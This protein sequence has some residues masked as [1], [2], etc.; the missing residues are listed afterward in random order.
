M[1]SVN[2]RL[3][4]RDKLAIGLLISFIAAAFSIELYWL[5]HRNELPA[6]AGTQFYARLFRI[7]SAGDRHY[8]DPVTALPVALESINV[9]FTQILNAW[10]IYA[11]V[12]RRAYR[13][14]LQLLVSSYVAYSVILYFAEAHFAG[15][16]A[17][18]DKSAWGFFIFW[19]P[20]LPWL[21]GHMY[22]AADSFVALSRQAAAVAARAS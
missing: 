3:G 2:G 10:L 8:Y 4:F 16:A 12:K 18:L 22:M 20:N 5:L 7:Y 14:P 11:I 21:L 17:M 15:Y 13:H 19:V 1:S 6:L 9:Y